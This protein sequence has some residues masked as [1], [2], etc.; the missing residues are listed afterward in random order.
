MRVLHV[1]TSLKCGGA[2]RLMTSLLPK[3]NAMG[4]QTDLAV[5]DGTM[6]PF[7]KDLLSN[8]VKI[9]RLSSG[10]KA[11][12]NPLLC[13]KLRRLLGKY[14][15]AHSHN[16]PAQIILA[17]GA[18]KKCHLI[19]TEHSVSNRRRAYPTLRTF[20]RWMYSHYD[21]VV[22]VS[23]DVA[24][25]LGKWIGMEDKIEVV[26][27]G[28][29]LDLFSPQLQSPRNDEK[30][31]IAMTA[32]F[33]Y[34]KDQ[35]SLIQSLVYLPECYHLMLAGDGP[36][37]GFCKNLAQTL[38]ISHRIEFKGR[39]EDMPGFLSMAYLAVLSTHYEGMP[40]AALEAMA[41]G[42]PM[43]CTDAPGVKEAVGDAAILVPISDSSSMAQAIMR[44]GEDRKY[45]AKKAKESIARA[46]EYSIEACADRHLSL[47]Q[48]IISS[49]KTNTLWPNTYSIE[50]WR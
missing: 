35:A 43:V 27:N 49:P 10:S 37:L 15:I 7:M 3:L 12:R 45:R 23:Q 14:D 9:H 47:Y 38:E 28:V 26:P 4:C 1:I 32:S 11:M 8:G 42:L 40:M 30:V 31:R 41:M 29:D 22:C 16:T 5:M 36:N 24:D 50:A 34:P 21:R 18:D 13:L 2:E 33:C 20:D 46:R 25:S 6:T 19:T 48:E 44:I 39:V 17:L